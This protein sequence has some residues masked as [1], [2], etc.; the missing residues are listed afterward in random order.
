MHILVIIF[1][2]LIS[3][4]KTFSFYFWHDDFSVLYQAVTK[5]CTLPWPY[6]SYCSLFTFLHSSFGIN[7]R[8]YFLLGGIL[9]IVF[10]LIFYLFLKR[11]YNSRFSFLLTLLLS[12]SYLGLGVFFESYDSI[13]SFLSLGTYFLALI[14]LHDGISDAKRRIRIFYSLAIFALSIVVLHA[15]SA[16][17]IFPYLTL[18][19]LYAKNI[20]FVKKSLLSLLSIAT[21]IVFFNSR[22]ESTLVKLLLETNFYD[23]LTIFIKNLVNGLFTDYLSIFFTFSEKLKLVVG[24]TLLL[25]FVIVSFKIIKNKKLNSRAFIFGL[26][27]TFAF[28]LPYALR[29]DSVLTTNHRYFW[30]V[31]LGLLIL[32]GNYLHLRIIRTILVVLIFLGI[33]QANYYF[34][35]FSLES[36]D[37]QT[38]YEQI[39]SQLGAITKRTTIYIDTSESQY[40]KV[41]DFFR[42]GAFPSEAAIATYLKTNYKNLKLINDKNEFARALQAGDLDTGNLYVFYYDKGKL[43]NYTEEIKKLLSENKSFVANINKI[44]STKFIKANDLNTGL[45]DEYKF[46]LKDFVGLLPSQISI[47]MKAQVP[48][49]PVPFSQECF[50]CEYNQ[51]IAATYSYITLSR[52][53]KDKVNAS[54]SNSWED[55]I[56]GSLVDYDYSTYWIANRPKWFENEKPTLKLH[57]NQRVSVSGLSFKTNF[58]KRRPSDLEIFLDGKKVEFQ[59]S[60]YLDWTS[61]NFDATYVQTIEIKILNTLGGDTPMIEE[62]G[63]T[64]F[65]NT[66]IPFAQIV[67][68]R[69]Y[70]VS[71]IKEYAEKQAF[72]DYANAGITLCLKWSTSD[73]IEKTREFKIYADGVTRTYNFIIP[74]TGVKSP[75]FS[76]GCVNYPLTV[77]LFSVEASLLGN[78]KN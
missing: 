59:K 15:R 77:S 27:T 25:F 13:T 22:G 29:Y 61:I 63:F 3:I 35:K 48:D 34:E 55:T 49:F 41:S 54:V 72:S 7:P 1:V 52:I 30:P 53:I 67:K 9:F 78:N 4:Y 46:H 56:A 68:T 6:T 26:V 74:S 50:D 43:T 32:L 33:F 21:Y 51:N 66:A 42:V 36:Y 19:F 40:Q 8:L 70:P 2:A 18:I 16:T 20:S 75:V 58:E 11:I 39:E 37:R 60:T 10:C 17:Y 28:Y 44:I 57:F 65:Q 69:L 71:Y 62:I 45:F 14:F 12:T 5:E 76:L 31:W 23:K 38:F 73:E 64:P 24:I 47:Q